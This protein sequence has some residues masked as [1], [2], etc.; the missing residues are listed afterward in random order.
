LVIFQI[1]KEHQKS[2]EIYKFKDLSIEMKSMKSTVRV[3]FQIT[4]QRFSEFVDE[5]NKKPLNSFQIRKRFFKEF[6]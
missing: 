3:K 5:N 2:R 4:T 1:S 6:K